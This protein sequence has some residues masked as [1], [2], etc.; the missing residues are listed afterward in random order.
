MSPAVRREVAVIIGLATALLT[1]YTWGAWRPLPV[2]QD[3]FSYVLQARIFGAGHWVAPPPPS[4]AAFQQPHVVVTP[5]LASKYPPGHALLLAPGAIVG[6]VWLV[7]VILAGVS[8][9]L[10]FLLMTETGPVFTAVC[11]W[12]Y[13]VSDPLAL[14]FRPGYY[15]ENTSG[16][17]WLLAWWLLLRWRE[18]RQPRWLVG[19]SVAVAWCAITR[20]F[21]AIALAVPLAIYL[22][23]PL[24][25]RRAWKDIAAAGVAGVCVL[26][27][28]A[29]ANY[30]V[31]GK[32]LKTAFG[33]YR[34]Q[35]LPFD[36]LG[37][38]LDSTPPRFQLIP[39]NADNYA[40]LRAVHVDHVPTQLPKIA[41]L[42][43]K[44]LSVAEWSDWR[45]LFVPVIA[46][47]L[48]AMSFVDWLAVASAALLF[49][50]YLLWAHWHGWTI[51]YF[52]ALPVLALAV[53]NGLRVLTRKI[54]HTRLAIGAATA[55]A[56]LYAIAS[57][58]T[59]TSWR[60]NHI[61]AARYGVAFQDALNNLPYAGS[62]VFVRYAADKR[63]HATL[64]ANSPTWLHDP[65]WVV[66]SWSPAT[67]LQ[68]M[69]VSGQRVPLIFDEKIGTISVYQ[70]LVDSL[71][72]RSRDQSPRKSQSSASRSPRE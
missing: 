32:P 57:W 47:G 12:A 6:A 63:S 20:P 44:E 23:I 8:G 60:S 71:R 22:S 21:T 25:V 24:I 72:Q 34:E 37:F 3:E 16:L 68:L 10:L 62:V 49:L 45:V 4:E 65:V 38:H 27:L 51:Y 61:E 29:F 42:R 5:H 54:P 7:P 66:N 17:A 36:K 18:S 59:I 41:W 46:I 50:S 69:S 13:W 11:G 40:E 33:L 1:W 70:E 55:F 26:G 48:C 14:R 9:A 52:E 2:V 67:D 58:R 19:L 53:S 35:Y 39:P 15:S 28:F 31:T 30:T 56:F 43:L 64:V